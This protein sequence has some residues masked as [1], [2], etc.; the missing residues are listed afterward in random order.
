M[1]AA[2]A[3]VVGA[4]AAVAFGQMT[5]TKLDRKL[6]ETTGGGRFVPIPGFPGESIDRRLLADIKFLVRKYKIFITDGYSIDPVHAR[7]G[8]H[9]IG[10][11]LD[12]VPD[13]T[14]TRR[15]RKVT[16][17]A[18]WAEPVPGVP[19]VPFRWVGYNGDIGHGRGHHLHLSWSHS[20]TE[21]EDP[22]RTVYTLKCPEKAAPA[23]PPPDPDGG[24]V[25][26]RTQRR[27]PDSGGV[28]ARIRAM[29]R[30]A[31]PERR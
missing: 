18:R 7:N 31:V 17:L 13:T 21:P 12:I 9:P 4:L 5:S 25:A 1:L 19:R 29:Q 10:L 30:T 11:A 8:E 22:A 28:A 23:P 2:A 27:E 24:G 6:C 15:W 20:P 16:R 3:V 14:K 26:S